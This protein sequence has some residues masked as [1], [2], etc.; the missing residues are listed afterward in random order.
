MTHVHRVSFIF[1]DFLPVN[2]T[3]KVHQKN[4]QSP[5]QLDDRRNGPR[6]GPKK[7]RT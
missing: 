4:N 7:K 3:H 6:M 1:V 5:P 2:S